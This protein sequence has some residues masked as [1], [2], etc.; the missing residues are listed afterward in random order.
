MANKLT[1]I[2][3]QYR[4]YK[5]D[6]VL[7]HTQLNE[8]IAFF[9]DQDRLTRVFLNGVGLVCGFR[10]KLLSNP[11]RVSIRQ[12]VG[13]TT[14]GDLLKLL[15]D[16]PNESAKS[17]VDG[18]LEYSHYHAFE[19]IH[20]N[21]P[22][23]LNGENRIN[24]WEIVP[25]SKKADTDLPLQNL[26]GLSEKVVVLYLET[27]AKEADLCGG[28][29]CDNQGVEQVARLRVLLTDKEGAD[30]LMS[31]DT[32][33]EKIDIKSVYAS[34]QK[35]KLKRVLLSKANTQKLQKLEDS[36]YAA[37]NSLN[38]NQ[39][40]S[41]IK[42]I[43][44]F[45]GLNKNIE[46]YINQFALKPHPK[47]VNQFQYD[48]DWLKDVV[49]TYHE[50]IDQL[51][52]LNTTCLPDI[53]AFP[54]H[55]MLGI[56]GDTRP[57]AQYRHSF[58]KS[59]ITGDSRLTAKLH[60]L[61]ER[62]YL[63]LKLYRKSATTLRITPSQQRGRLGD[64]AIPVY[65]K[66]N[67]TL[68]NHWS[69]EKTAKG[70]QEDIYQYEREVDPA[71]NEVKFEPLEYDVSNYDFY[72][73]EGHIGQ[74]YQRAL[75]KIQDMVSTY[76]LDFDVKA[77]SIDQVLENIKMEDYKCHFEDLMV[78]LEAWND[79]ISCITG[80]IS[81][82]FSSLDI[83][84]L[85]A[86]NTS[87]NPP[88]SPAIREEAVATAKPS[89]KSKQMTLEKLATLIKSGK[90]T[91]AEAQRLYPYLFE[92]TKDYK[93]KT[94][95]SIQDSISKNINKDT[96]ALG[97]VFDS[98]IKSRTETYY[99]YNDIKVA[100]EKEAINYIKD[101]N[102]TAD[103][104]ATFIDKPIEIIAASYD[105]SNYIPERLFELDNTYIGKYETSIESLCLK[106]NEFSKRIEKLDLN[107]R[108]KSF[109]QSQ[110]LYYTSICCAAN[111]LKIL[112]AEIE[113]RK[114]I[115]LEG[116]QLNKF[117]EHHPGL[118]HQAGV[119][120]GGTFVM[121][122]Y[123]QPA[124]TG[125]QF[126]IGT[127][128]GSKEGTSRTSA[129]ESKIIDYN[130]LAKELNLFT[131][132]TKLESDLDLLK[133]RLS[134][135]L[136]PSSLFELT[137]GQLKSNLKDKTVIA[138]FMLPY[139][140]C[141][142]C[143]PINFIVPRPVVFLNLDEDTY[144]LGLDQ[145]PVS[146][147]VI[148]ADGEIKT[149]EEIPGVII[150]TS[151]ISIDPALFPKA[152]LG[153]AISFT[154]NG[155]T[156]NAELTVHQ[157]PVFV[158]NL[159]DGPVSNPTLSLSA[160]PV[161]EGAAYAWDFGDGTSSTDKNPQKTYQLPINEENKVTISLTITPTNGACPAEVTG[162]ILFEQAD[163]EV[164]L[165]LNPKEICR[166]RQTQPIPFEV[167]PEN[168]VVDGEGV[169][170]VS[171]KYVFNPHL[172]STIN[173]GKELNFTVNGESTDLVVRIF[174]R[175]TV[176]FTASV[177]RNPSNAAYRVTFTIT[178]PFPSGT[179]YRWTIEDKTLEPTT[180]TTLVQDFS[181]DMDQ[182]TAFVTVD[183]N[184]L[185]EQAQSAVQTIS[186]TTD[187]PEPGQCMEEGNTFIQTEAKRYGAFLN[188]PDFEK[189]DGWGQGILSQAIDV[190]V[191]TAREAQTYLE[192]KQNDFITEK[193]TEQINNLVEY[194][195][196]M[197]SGNGPGM[198]P[199]KALYKVYIKL[200]YMLI[201]CQPEE[202]FDINKD[203]FNKVML[204]ITETMKQLIEF[205]V[206]WDVEKDMAA[207]FEALIKV[208]TKAPY[209]QE[210]IRE[211]MG[212]IN[213]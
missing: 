104:K 99:S 129:L 101:I 146:F 140:C 194:M 181:G 159:P 190:L 62:L 93:T 44:D 52:N 153:Q 90:I 144:C 37:I 109:Y 189:I 75:I 183:L 76:N 173:L 25:E 147:E 114:K 53:K 50:I 184:N 54:K 178:S 132:P 4:T 168:G 106:L 108:L 56:V 15:E 210:A 55:L 119:P 182:I 70:F 77:L 83:K 165:D 9:E 1:A 39:L 91:L 123:T 40:K 64:K 162:E 200:F 203:Q 95:T 150:G 121:V 148:P 174:E 11:T 105:I 7:T 111:K 137:M 97:I 167:T 96:E 177:A 17:L 205:K 19:D 158:L 213:S 24:L 142:D 65:Y 67:P 120:K 35:V 12:G 73:V 38:L 193:I 172:V 69:Y 10:T 84:K 34:L 149:S 116:L 136:Q 145:A 175:P 118:E 85:L 151:A 209:V 100:A 117:I 20:G 94:R 125:N 5:V 134:A 82:F 157:S 161:F 202:N 198:P 130:S 160:S 21:Y 124:R 98:S 176:S 14:D 131:D 81:K 58:Y 188:S 48:Y 47:F 103:Y 18:D 206:I 68:L 8:S 46:S 154:V 88:P 89:E 80:K 208:F 72:R 41:G 191:N 139:R 207:Y 212:L 42:A 143:N 138:D 79:E 122:Y 31:K 135:G 6:Q 180:S 2:T 133:E 22:R 155:E 185:C 169:Q 163:E 43:S 71:T 33:Y 3:T 171:G 61:V 199:A 201:K 23:F 92:S 28:I 13:V 186:L 87:T 49:D 192:G 128:L 113:A 36:Y 16:I 32:V 141:S 166:D 66:S 78:L 126:T 179:A 102:I 156:V 127:A 196:E 107:D 204:R 60:L 115:I 152:M 112:Q 63:L 26:E 164:S 110:A 187:N 211:Q 29:D 74:D 170:L 51:F 86:A 59:P 195:I 30:Y 197:N 27:Y 45:L 57:Y